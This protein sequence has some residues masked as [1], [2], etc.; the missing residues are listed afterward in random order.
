MANV[1]FDRTNDAGGGAFFDRTNNAE[2]GTGFVNATIATV[3]ALAPQSTALGYATVV[4]VDPIYT[5]PGSIAFTSNFTG[6]AVA[7]DVVRYPTTNNFQVLPDASIQCDVAT[8]SYAC[9]YNDGGGEDAFTVNLDGD[10]DVFAALATAT[11][12][13]VDG[14][15][16]GNVLGDASAALVTVTATAIDGFAAEPA[17]ADIGTATATS[18]DGTASAPSF[19]ADAQGGI[20]NTVASAPNAT[21]TGAAVAS[22]DVGTVSATPIEGTANESGRADAF[23]ALPTVVVAEFTG[24]GRAQWGKVASETTIWTRVS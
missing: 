1:F 14:S 12:V 9:F 10:A 3:S 7:G 6:T 16:V 15:A 19:I 23:G 11:A 8:G 18:P 5:G 17:L 20:A 4:L 22:C 21:A 2:D 13:T 24:R